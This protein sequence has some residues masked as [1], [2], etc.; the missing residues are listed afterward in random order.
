[1]ISTFANI[2][3][4]TSGNNIKLKRRL[5]RIILEDE[6][7]HKYRQKKKVNSDIKTISI[8]LKL[9]LSLLAYNPSLQKI[10]V[11]VKSRSN[12]ISFKHKKTNELAK[13][14]TRT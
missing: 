10:N 5:A 3:L 11:A 9:S 2:R 8:Q 12:A 1:M 7:Q 14:T 4:A 6:L 13:E